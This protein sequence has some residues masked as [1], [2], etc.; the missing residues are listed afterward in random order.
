VRPRRKQMRGVE[1]RGLNERPARPKFLIY[2]QML[3]CVCFLF[4]SRP[5]DIAIH[6]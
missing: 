2:L 3:R 4:L 1:I 6:Q 5:D